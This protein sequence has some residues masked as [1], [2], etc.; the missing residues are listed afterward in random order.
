MGVYDKEPLSCN[1]H[2][3]KNISYLV[4]KPLMETLFILFKH[5]VHLLNCM[6]V[7]NHPKSKCHMFGK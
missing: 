5:L 2:S 3:D 7:S 6:A 4:K 1:G